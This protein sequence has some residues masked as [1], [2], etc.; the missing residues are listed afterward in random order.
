MSDRI[1]YKVRKDG[2]LE[3]IK[4]Y[5]SKTNGARYKVILDLKNMR[6]AAKNIRK[7]KFIAPK[8][9]NYTNLNVL[10]RVARK[11]LEY[12]GVS[13]VSEVR[14]RNFGR[15]EKGYSQREHIKKEIE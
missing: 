13:L 5:V 9:Q 11:Y 12:L 14:N 1:R 4:T 2:K 10:K 6:F 8:E 15:C 3:S 7:Q